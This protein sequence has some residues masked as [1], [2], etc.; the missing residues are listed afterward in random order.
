M[1]HGYSRTLELLEILDPL[2]R[3]SILQRVLMLEVLEPFSYR[4]LDF[5]DIPSVFFKYL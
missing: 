4:F 1:D 3:S 2:F 5:R